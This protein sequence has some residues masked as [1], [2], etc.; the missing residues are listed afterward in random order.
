MS[1]MANKRNPG[2]FTL[3]ANLMNGLSIGAQYFVTPNVNKVLSEIISYHQAG[4]HSFTIIG[5]YGTGKSSFLLNLERD[6]DNSH[7]PKVLLQNK[8]VL[9]DGDVEILNIL[10]DSKSL[11][12][13][14]HI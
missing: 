2:N 11:F 12:S 8:N 10:G 6:M 1:T 14:V 5:T 7:Q 9:I 13:Q 3:S 4:L